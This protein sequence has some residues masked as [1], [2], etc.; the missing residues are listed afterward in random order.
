MKRNIITI[1][2]IV[3]LTVMTAFTASAQK[4]GY[5]NSTQILAEHPGI[6][7]ADSELEAYQKQLVSKGESMV[8]SFETKY[9]AYV[10]EAQGGTLSQ[11]QMQQKESQLAEEQK[12]IQNYEVE[13]QQKILK[14]RE[15]LYKP[16]LDKINSTL[17]AL[18]KENGYTMIFDSSAG[19][20]LY[21]AEGEDITSLLKSKLGM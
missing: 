11:V 12:A 18:G 9:Q 6:K 10:Q 8:K 1:C 13:V 20:L 17:E 14:K 16:V 15:D 3:M 4:F 7:S 19:G 2:S 5:V 21:A